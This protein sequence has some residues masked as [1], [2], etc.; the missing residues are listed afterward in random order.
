MSDTTNARPALTMLS[1]DE[2]AFRD[3]VR[4]FA[5]SEI[6]PHVTHMD[7]KAEMDPAIVKKLFEMG[8]MG[9]ET[10]EKFGGAGSTFTMACLAVEEIGRVDGSVSVLVDVQNTL[11]TNAFLKWGTPAQQEKYLSKMASEWVGAYALSESS[12]GSDAFALKLKAED[13]GDKWVLNGSKLWITNGKEAN[14]FI[15]FANIDIAKGYKGITAF[16]VEKSFPG[17]KVGKKEDKLGIRAS[18]T[19]ELLF[20]NCEVPKENVLGE[21]GKGYKIAIETLNEGRIGIG[22]QMIGI[23]QGAYEAAL[24][25][26]KGR[27]QFGKPIAHFQG[28]QFQLAEMRTELEAARLMVYNAARLKDAGQDFIEAAAMAKLYASRA[29]EKITSKAI[30][31]F[32]GNGFTK[33]YPVEKFWRDA[34][35]GQIYEGTTNMQLQTIAKMELDK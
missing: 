8:L 18:S 25:Y 7:E 20:E 22:A 34:K 24:G 31:L 26:V 35:I 33:E 19:C 23:A 12:S 21:V 30:D 16:I 6:K 5:E 9:I 13:K 29:A 11:T 2:A 4:A 32:G 14:V 3:A 15:V 10:P 1:E 27:E 28:V 17:F